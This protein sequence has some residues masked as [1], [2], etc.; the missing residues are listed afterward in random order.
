[1]DEQ[2]LILRNNPRLFDKIIG[3]MQR[4]L[5]AGLPWLNHIFGRAERLVREVGGR[6]FYSPNVYAGGNDYI[7]VAPDSQQLGNFCFFT[8]DDP[9]GVTW[10]PGDTSQL[11]APFSLIVWVDMRTIGVGENRNTEAVKREILTVLNGGLWLREGRMTISRIYERAENVFAGFSL[12]E[13]ENQYLMHPFCGWRFNGELFI[14]DD[15]V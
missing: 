9:Q 8:L 15:C 11:R 7:L 2:H 6:R 10:S 4:G 5:A 1:M 13:V 12:D 3:D 14:N